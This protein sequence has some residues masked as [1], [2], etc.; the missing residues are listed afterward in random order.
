MMLPGPEPAEKDPSP[1]MLLVSPVTETLNFSPR[2]LVKV[3]APP[4]VPLTERP[5]AS[6]EA[7][8]ENWLARSVK[9]RAVVVEPESKVRSTGLVKPAPVTRRVTPVG[10][11]APA[12]DVPPTT[13]VEIAVPVV[14]ERLPSRALA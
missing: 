5:A 14:P 6:K 9:A 11:K 1:R 3:R 10:V 7:L 8:V 13:V 12:V 2:E 4:A